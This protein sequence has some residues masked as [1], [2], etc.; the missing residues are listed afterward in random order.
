[1]LSFELGFHPLVVLA[2]PTAGSESCDLSVINPISFCNDGTFVRER[3]RQCLRR[4]IQTVDIDK[5]LYR[6]LAANLN[7]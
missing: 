7:V 3:V 1:M 5:T 6:L 2:M 4:I